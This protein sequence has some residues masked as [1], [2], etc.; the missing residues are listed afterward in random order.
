M[1]RFRT[2]DGVHLAYRDHGAGRPIVFVPGWGMP[3]TVF[4]RQV[5]GLSDRFRVI[6]LDPRG[7][8]RSPATVDGQFMERRASDVG[9]LIEHL[10]LREVTLVAWS[11]GI[12]EALLYADSSNAERLRSLVLVDGVIRSGLNDWPVGYAF[13]RGLL[14]E[15]KAWTAQFLAMAASPDIDQKLRA[16]VVRSIEG[17]AIHCAYALLLDYC[18]TDT[19]AA[20]KRFS[21]PVLYVH[22]SR[23][24][25]QA[26]LIA[27]L[28]QNAR[29]ECFD[30]CG[31]MLF[32]ERGDRF[33]RLLVEFTSPDA[34]SV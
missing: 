9:E 1:G 28:S 2:S 5:S 22:Q 33:N 17:L 25:E 14:R 24:Q 3:G 6:V 13:I 27:E 16:D 12:S 20:L 31:H 19:S 26:A 8:G 7:Q 10:K 29:T 32:Y 23:M 21:K 34:A 18:F 4:Q 11:M 30:D 15:P